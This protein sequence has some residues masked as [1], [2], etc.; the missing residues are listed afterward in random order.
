ME[1]ALADLLAMSGTKVMNRVTS[2]KPLD[3]VRFE[4]VRAAFARVL[5]QLATA[6]PV[7]AGSGRALAS[8]GARSEVQSQGGRR[9]RGKV[10]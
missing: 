4:Q 2:R 7:I 1:K 3:E 10:K 9:G 5:P 6:S 8:R